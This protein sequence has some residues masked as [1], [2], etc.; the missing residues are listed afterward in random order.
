MRNRMKPT[1]ANHPHS[2]SA[3][4]RSAAGPWERSAPG[5]LRTLQRT[6]GNAATV[7]ALAAA[8]RTPIQRFHSQDVRTADGEGPHFATQDTAAGLRTRT[9]PPA[10]ELP[11]E[12]THGTTYRSPS[13][14]NAVPMRVSDRLDLAVH[15]V[16]GGEP[17]EFYCDRAV[18]DHA[19]ERLAA[20]GSYFRL[21]WTSARI[22]V[23]EGSDTRTLNRVVPVPAEDAA[24]RFAGGLKDE[25]IEFARLVMGGTRVR[26]VPTIAA[27]GE[28]YSESAALELAERVTPAGYGPDPVAAYSGARQ[29]GSLTGLQDLEL[30]E[31]AAPQVGE[32]F[33][34]TTLVSE[35]GGADESLSDDVWKF[36]FAGVVAR[37]GDDRVTLENY[38]RSA[39]NAV[40]QLH[41]QL[42]GR[43]RERTSLLLRKWHALRYHGRY[44]AEFAPIGPPMKAVLRLLEQE[45][46]RIG[47]DGQREFNRLTRDTLS[48][49]RWFFRMYGRRPGQSFHEQKLG[50][51][52]PTGRTDRITMSVRW[53][54][55]T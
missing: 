6:A 19:S 42:I 29:A 41:A 5:V 46:A 25:C 28:R 10:G 48:G 16:P 38:R 40:A 53:Q 4:D 2:R 11:W 30:N 22:E 17:K 50:T 49:E 26:Q 23:G 7:R 54:R 9:R 52:D 33:N 1:P 15:D 44:D 18:F 55:T 3:T 51:P 27:T 31:F 13:A 45:A 24:S 8:G 14:E 20:V 37:S 34:Y 35:D 39:E 21:E 43:Y 47:A 36:H 12:I 32:A